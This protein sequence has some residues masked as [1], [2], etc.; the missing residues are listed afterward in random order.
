MERKE[1]EHQLTGLIPLSTSK[2]EIKDGQPNII[3]WK[4]LSETGELLGSVKEL[5]FDPVQQKV[6]YLVLNLEGNV[7]DLENRE[8]LIPMMIAELDISRHFVFLALNAQQIAA[9]PTYD[10]EHIIVSTDSELYGQPD[11]ATDGIPFQIITKIYQEEN[12][13]ENAFTLLLQNGLAEKDIKVTSHN[14]L[15]SVTDLQGNTNTEFIGDSSR[16]E[17]ILNVATYTPAEADLVH[18]LLDITNN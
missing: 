8:I 10:Q 9:L 14:P 7:W 11:T 5:L 6:A 16:D 1:N 17:Y 18:Q 12:E 13:A 15:N 4:T 3:S 2:F